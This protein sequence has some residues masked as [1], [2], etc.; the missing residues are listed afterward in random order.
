MESEEG[1]TPFESG[2]DEPETGEQGAD[3]GTQEEA[4]EEAGGDEG[5]EEGA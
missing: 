3:T 1:A 4:G 2:N 5:G